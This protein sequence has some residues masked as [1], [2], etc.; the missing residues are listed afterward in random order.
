MSTTQG[1]SESGGQAPGVPGG[2][3]P[4]APAGPW[5]TPPPE[6]RPRRGGGLL[7]GL[8]I[9]LA[10]LLSAAALVVGVVA[11]VRQPATSASSASSTS[12]APSQAGDTTAADKALCTAIAPAMGDSDRI[13]NAYVALGQAGSPERDAALPKFVTDTK[14]WTHRA[15]GVLDAHPDAQAFLMRS[16]QRYID[17][18]RLLAAE[19]RPGPLKPYDDE[20]WSDSMAAY[21][22]PLSVCGDLGVTW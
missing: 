7:A 15:Q 16:V 18:R 3:P 14:D 13:S 2:F 9:A 6:Q 5:W 22:G 1:Q 12:S 17:D 10:L 20:I 19:L 21:S 11:L 4:N 8:G